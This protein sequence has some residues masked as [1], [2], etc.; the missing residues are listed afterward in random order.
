[1]ESRLGLTRV[2]KLL[3]WS[4]ID[5]Y[6]CR[7]L[8]RSRFSA[9][10]HVFPRFKRMDPRWK[11]QGWWHAA[12]I[13]SDAGRQQELQGS[14]GHD[15]GAAFGRWKLALLPTFTHFSNLQYIYIYICTDMCTPTSCKKIMGSHSN[16]I[17]GILKSIPH[18]HWSLRRV[19]AHLPEGTLLTEEEVAKYLGSLS[20]ASCEKFFL[21]VEGKICDITWWYVFCRSFWKCACR[22]L[23]MQTE[24]QNCWLLQCHWGYLLVATE[25]FQ[26]WWLLDH[27]PRPCIRRAKL[28]QSCEEEHV[29]R[30]RLTN[31]FNQVWNIIG[32]AFLFT[33]FKIS[34]ATHFLEGT[35]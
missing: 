17:C 2:H 19:E 22:R 30:R 11:L 23:K 25:A 7:K 18:P 1:M 15:F 5:A 28:S 26:S 29:R 34:L 20:F 13:S 33:S 21:F 32:C 6:D 8:C 12:S 35:Q 4:N 31:S 10:S 14:A 27:F 3:C 16:S 9:F 24:T